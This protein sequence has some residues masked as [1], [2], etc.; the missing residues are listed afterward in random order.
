M[1]THQPS[2]EAQAKCEGAV[3]KN[4]SNAKH[5]EIVP[6]TFKTTTANLTWHH[7]TNKEDKVKPLG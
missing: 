2:E 4:F 7:T 1:P 6:L 5:P 3:I